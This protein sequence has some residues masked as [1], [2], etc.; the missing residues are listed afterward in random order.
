MWGLEFDDPTPGA[1]AAVARRIAERSAEAG[2]L[3]LHADNMIRINPPLTITVDE[4][5]FVVDTLK[6]VVTEVAA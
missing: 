4:V 6:S 5:R 3:V 1:G 2:L